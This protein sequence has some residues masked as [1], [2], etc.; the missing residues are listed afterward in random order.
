MKILLVNNYYYYRGGDCTYLFSLKK[1]LENH[2]HKVV[3][4]SMK[5]PQNLDSEYSR[6]FVSYISYEEEIRTISITSGVKVLKR[7]IYSV[8][9]RKR[10]K[11]LIEIEKPD[12]AHIQN[13]HHHITPSILYELKKNNIPIIWTLHD[14]TLI[15]PN[16]SFLS[17]G[18]ICEKCKK[19]KYFWPVLERCKKDSVTASSVAVMETTIHRI[20]NFT[21]LVD[22]FVAPSKFLH[23]KF[24]EY[25]FKPKKIARIDLFTDIVAQPDSAL[26]FGD[27]IM[28]VGRISEE[29]GIKTLID[30]VLEV[31]SVRLKIVGTGP[32]LDKVVNYTYFRDKKGMIEFLGYKGRKELA[33][34][35]RNCKFVIVPSEWYEISGLIIFETFAC[36]KPIIG[37][38]IGGIPE[39]VNDTKRGLVFEPGDRKD[40]IACIRYLLNNPDLVEEMG[41]NARDFILNEMGSEVH[42]G[43]LIKIYEKLTNKLNHR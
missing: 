19:G 8:E 11:R 10:I 12:I 38:R 9:A 25:G 15:C 39:L 6:Y 33:E 41:R 13:I 24:I 7:T 14:Y 31:G 5:H 34:L 30:A 17:H 16:T 35:Y 23:D 42:Y 2:G 40:L 37:S 1:L 32:L 4:F 20:M 28:Y 18:K 22:C 27:Y 26:S 36:G 3:V 29:K 43:K 21:D